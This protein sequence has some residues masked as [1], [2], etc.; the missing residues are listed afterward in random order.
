MS[1]TVLDKNE[2]QAQRIV[3]FE[4]ISRV[5]PGVSF[6]AVGANEGLTNVTIRGI[7]STSGAATVGI[8]LDDVSITTKNFYDFAAMPR[9]VDLQSIEVLR[10]PQGS[11][12]GASSEGGTIRFIPVAPNMFERS[13]EV[14]LD[15]SFTRHGSINYGGTAI[16]NAPLSPGVFALRGSVS[17]NSDSGYINNFDQLG[18]LAN[19]RVN[20]ESATTVHLLGKLTPGGDLTITPG[21]FYQDVKTADNAAFYPALG[22]F[23]E[24][25]QVREFGE[26]KMT[27]ASLDRKSV[28]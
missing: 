1:I 22:L 21:F 23:N 16:F 9:F 7:S 2:L 24:S 14:S 25:K 18:N 5:V 4:D 17:A 10:G 3:D 19:K 12:W 20:H 6:N 13:G 8:Y 28:V 26:D 27:L 15:T 11:L